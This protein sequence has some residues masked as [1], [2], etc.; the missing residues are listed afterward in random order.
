MNTTRNIQYLNIGEDLLQM[1]CDSRIEASIRG[2]QEKYSELRDR[3]NAISENW[4]KVSGKDYYIYWKKK[5]LIPDTRKMKRTYWGFYKDA[6]YRDVLSFIRHCPPEVSEEFRQEA[7]YEKSVLPSKF[8]NK[9]SGL[10]AVGMDIS[11]AGQI[12]RDVECPMVNRGMYIMLDQ[13]IVTE[14]VIVDSPVSCYYSPRRGKCGSV[15]NDCAAV[16]IS[17]HAFSESDTLFDIAEHYG[18][19]PDRLGEDDK[20][21]LKQFAILYRQGVRIEEEGSLKAYI[22]D[23]RIRE[24]LGYTFEYDKMKKDVLKEEID[25]TSDSMASVSLKKYL[26]ECDYHRARIQ[27]YNSRWYLSDEEKGHWD[28]WHIGSSSD[29]QEKENAKSS[30]NRYRIRIKGGAIARN[31]LA[32]IRYDAVVGIDFGTKS[33]IVAVQDGNDAIIPMRVGM[34]DYLEAPSGEHYRNPTVIQFI[35]FRAFC[36]AYKS[37]PG[38]PYTSWEDVK[39]SHEAL[40]DMIDAKESSEYTAFISDLKQWAGGKYARQ[41]GV[42]KVIRDKKGFRYDLKDYSELT[43]EDFDPIELYAYYLGLFINNMHTGIY[44][45]YL[46]SFPETYSLEARE[47]M[48]SSFRKGIKHSLPED[49]FE[50]EEVNA[51]FR[52]RQSS[53]EPA[54]YAACALEQYGILPTDQGIFYGIFDFGGGTTDFDFGV[55]KNAPEDEF[56]YN[57][58]ISH[59]GSGGD[60][61]LGGENLLELLAYNVFSDCRI[62]AGRTC[63]N[64]QIMRERRIVFYKP[65]EGAVFPG[66][67]ALVS[68]E[69]SAFLNSKQLMEVLRPIWELHETF[70]RWS[71]ASAAGTEETIVCGNNGSLLLHRDSSITARV[72][73]FNE[74]GSNK[75]EVD[76][77]VDMDLVNETFNTR[78]EG[79]VRN[80]FEAMREVYKEKKIA[81]EDPVHIFLAGNSSKSK[82]VSALFMHY[83][84]EYDKVMFS[85]RE[86]EAET[87]GEGSRT[88]SSGTSKNFLLFPPLGTKEAIEIQNRRGIKNHG[89][90]LMA[91]TG[92]TGVAFGM[93]MCREGS[94]IRVESELK[95][96]AQIK[97]NYYVGINYRRKFRMIFDRMVEYDKWLV[98]MKVPQDA[99]TFEVYYTESPEVALGNKEIK[100]DPSIHK[101]KCLLDKSGENAYIYFRF[102]SPSELEYVVA[103]E[104]GVEEEKYISSVYKVDLQ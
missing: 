46:L 13:G 50:D 53:S 90:D 75:I 38:R 31:P 35:D 6:S 56:S 23:N 88:V 12:F 104:D 22:T 82:R 78:I 43:E 25:L 74:K 44:L 15:T 30:E 100:N 5:I 14:Y 4:I 95:K 2:I 68:S 19:I 99:E 11:V 59:F 54:A 48:L 36:R 40:K 70:R 87:A 92:K 42:H 49:I 71:E 96:T 57:F 102:V 65:A 80:F 89:D 72:N 47:H 21:M 52:V 60:K 34:A 77:D 41:K 63:S 103:G 67:E 73:L 33:T 51:A 64:L 85:D 84:K 37:Q 69:E 39:I 66:A 32:D 20:K 97:L 76:L 86:D 1:F 17:Y 98:F 83:M 16:K 79:G 18:V 81:S 55:W 61:T 93:I 45:D 26:D 8:E 7:E 24:L 28:L 29:R 101:K 58:I 9:L 62:P 3:V 94:M 10:D 91:P 27:K